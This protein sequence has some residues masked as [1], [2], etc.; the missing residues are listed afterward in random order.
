MCSKFSELLFFFVAFIV[1]VFG[2]LQ[3][4][5][6]VYVIYKTCASGN[7][8]NIS[9]IFILI[10]G[11]SILVSFTLDDITRELKTRRDVI[12]KQIAI[13][14]YMLMIAVLSMIFLL[15]IQFYA[16]SSE[17]IIGELSDLRSFNRKSVIFR[18]MLINFEEKLGCCRFFSLVSNSFLRNCNCN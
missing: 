9:T 14:I 18:S 2:A 17:F 16:D 10:F 3:I 6:G 4:I 11:I 8:I 5:F 15:T 12:V 1:E 13:L 7:E